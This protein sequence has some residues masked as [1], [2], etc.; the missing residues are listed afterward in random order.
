M[1]ELVG[2][3]QRVKADIETEGMIRLGYLP[4][5]PFPAAFRP[6][7]TKGWADVAKREGFEMPKEPQER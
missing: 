6:I 7:F 5:V 2:S 4:E 1:R 3:G